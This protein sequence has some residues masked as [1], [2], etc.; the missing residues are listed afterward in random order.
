MSE[1][2]GVA[3]APAPNKTVR[4]Y[5][6]G[7]YKSTSNAPRPEVDSYHQYKNPLNQKNF[8]PN[9][10]NQ[11]Y[12]PHYPHGQLIIY[13][14]KTKCYYKVED[15]DTDDEDDEDDDEEE[16]ED[17][18]DEEDEDEETE[19][20][21]DDDENEETD[22]EDYESE[23]DLKPGEPN[24]VQQQ[25]K[26]G[27]QPK[28]KSQEEEDDDEEDEETEESEGESEIN[29]QGVCNLAVVF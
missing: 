21:E 28:L 2:K 23:E 24:R 27:E 29:V 17:E 5:H 18:D 25:Q 16:D 20:E 15:A 3:T 6:I 12:P 11:Q 4:L 7:G 22:E 9:M 8:L 13:D 26:I 1:N 10:Y 19:D 14:K